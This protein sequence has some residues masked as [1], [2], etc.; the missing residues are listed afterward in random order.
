TEQAN[1][2]GEPY[3]GGQKG[4]FRRRTVPVDEF[5][6]NRWGLYNVHGNVWEWT[7]D[8]WNENNEGN[9]GNGSA[10]TTD[11]CMEHV[12][13]GGSW[14]REPQSLRAANRSGVIV[15]DKPAPDVGFRL[16]RILL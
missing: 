10:R 5:E 15:D 14:L 1:Y 12:I 2:N 9:P 4:E 7:Q 8:C 6:A 3:G 11:D 16:A 13:R